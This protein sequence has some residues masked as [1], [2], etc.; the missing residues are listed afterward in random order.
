[1]LVELEVALEVELKL[2]LSVTAKIRKWKD[3]SSCIQINPD[4]YRFTH[5]F[6]NE[7]GYLLIS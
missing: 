5:L 4:T 6:S 3:K 1:M 7:M 2:Q